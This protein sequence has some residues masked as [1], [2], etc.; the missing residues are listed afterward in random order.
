VSY[1]AETLRQSHQ[2]CREVCRRS[3]SNFIASFRL[4]RP[5]KRR[6]MYA[7]YAFMRHTDDLGDNP[8]PVAK[9]AE[10][11][12]QWREALDDALR[13][14]VDS[15]RFP[16]LPAMADTVA[17]FSIPPEHLHAVIDGVEQ[18]LRRR[19]YEL[20]EDLEEYCRLVASAVGLACIHIWGFRG[21][22]AIPA[23]VKCGLAM[24]MTN[25]LRDL[26][27]DARAERVYLPLM[28][29]AGCGY[30]VEEIKDGTVNEAFERLMRM[31]IERARR[32]YD[33]GLELLDLLEPDGRR[34]F[35]MMMD[36]YRQ[37]LEEIA[38]EP[39]AVFTRRVRLSRWTKYRIAWRWLVWPR[40]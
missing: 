39:G 28:E 37:L 29:I 9:R 40:Q 31:Q 21:K 22:E 16:I 13:G 32:F 10:D 1:S 30:S 17:R 8:D 2:H 34:I 7:L 23:A 12:Q 35:G 20:Y 14:E 24:Q 11:I 3:Q 27:E 4:L 5:E 18:D 26:A 25:I 19:R 33:E 15:E 38:R 36:T 6:A